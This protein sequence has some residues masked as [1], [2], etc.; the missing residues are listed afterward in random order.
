MAVKLIQAI[1]GDDVALTA[2]AV[3]SYASAMPPA[4]EFAD[5]PQ[6]TGLFRMGDPVS[7]LP[8]FEDAGSPFASFSVDAL[9]AGL[10]LNVQTGKIHGTPSSPTARQD[11]TVT[12]ANLLGKTDFI[13]SL[14]VAGCKQLPPEKWT[15]GMCKA[16]LM[17]DL[18]MEERD[19]AHFVNID[20]TQLV[21]LQTK[22]DVASKFP[23]L[24]QSVSVSLAQSVSVL[25]GPWEQKKTTDDP[26]P[27][28]EDAEQT[29][30]LEQ[31]RVEAS[32]LS[33]EVREADAQVKYGAA[34]MVLGQPPDAGRGIGPFLNHPG[35]SQELSAQ[36]G[37]G[38][39]AI[40]DEIEREGSV[41]DKICLE[42]ILHHA[43]GDSKEKWQNGWVWDCYIDKVVVD[44]PFTLDQAGA[45]KG[46]LLKRGLLGKVLE[47]KKDGQP[48]RPG[49]PP[50]FAA[51]IEFEGGIGKCLVSREQYQNLAGVVLAERQMDDP[52]VPE[53]KRGWRFKDFCEHKI[54]QF[55]QLSEA[56]VLAL[57]FYTTWGYIDINTPLRDLERREKCLPH[58]LAVLVFILNE[59]IKQLRAWAG[60]CAQAQ[61]PGKH[62]QKSARYSI[63]YM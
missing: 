32:K 18:E 2:P 10:T 36:V 12:M 55:C 39:Q 30:M 37:K 6:S 7:M 56:H 43:A 20:G 3:L 35:G 42:Y 40:I 28:G 57:R 24:A 51:L 5:P 27:A 23:S 60:Q 9:P 38:M 11:Y 52:S 46:T 63:S 47:T 21:T 17:E 45:A 54:S 58:K 13:V 15:V 1:K 4:S 26:D 61:V 62:T 14:E 8:S 53:G 31:L 25:V 59:A 16:W 29:A 33:L 49:G 48:A 44:E 22:A 50:G 41:H 19:R 34:K